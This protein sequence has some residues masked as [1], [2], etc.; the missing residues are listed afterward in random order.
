MKKDVWLFGYG[1]LIWRPGFEFK[2]R[3]KASLRHFKR[4]FWQGSH[5]H[6]GTPDS[7]GRVVTLIPEAEQQCEGVAFLID[8]DI[9]AEIFGA[10]DHREKNG[11]ERHFVNLELENGDRVEGVVYIARVE[12]HAW[13][14]HAD[15]S[16]IAS[17]IHASAG[18]SGP[19]PE[20]LINL[21]NALREL[22]IHDDHVFAIEHHLKQLP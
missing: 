7:P 11:Y 18:P 17:Q 16:V 9:L 22:D 3:R 2:Q 19:N 8:R 13:L 15:I 4:R 21:A 1:S 10:L 20:Y 12:N 5:D 14:G 6:R